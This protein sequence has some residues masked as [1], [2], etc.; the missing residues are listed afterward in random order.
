[1]NVILKYIVNVSYVH[2]PDE[3]TLVGAIGD[4][5]WGYLWS[6]SSCNIFNPNNYCILK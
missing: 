3:E 1:M 4:M 5:I 6:V 2:N